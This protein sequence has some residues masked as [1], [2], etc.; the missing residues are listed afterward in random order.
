MT[1]LQAGPISAQLIGP[2]LRHIRLGDVEL[3]REIAVAVRD[4]EWGTIAPQLSNLDVRAGADGFAVAFDARHRQGELDFSW[5]GVISGD[6]Q[7][8]SFA[9]VGQAEADFA[10]RRIGICVLHPIRSCCGR[11]LH[12]RGPEGGHIQRMPTA[13]APQDEIDGS[14]PPLFPAFESLSLSLADDLELRFDFAGDLFEMEDQRNWTDASFKSYSRW[15]PSAPDPAGASSG[16]RFSQA[17]TVSWEGPIGAPALARDVVELTIGEPL[18]RRTPRLGVGRPPHAP[19]LQPAAAAVLASAGLDHLRI[20]VRLATDDV[21]AQIADGGDDARALG[22]DLELAVHLGADGRDD[23][24]LSSVARALGGVP[25][26]R[27]L[28]FVDG[29]DA[30]PPAA[31]AR[32]RAALAITAPNVAVGGGSDLNF[33]ELN[34]VRPDPRAFEVFSFPLTPTVHADD[35]AAIVS[36]LEAHRAV[37]ATIALF[38]GGRPAAI[39]PITLRPRSGAADQ[40]P[41]QRQATLFAAAWT[42][43]AVKSLGEAGA[44]SLTWF[45][46]AGPRGLMASNDQAT[47]HPAL[48]S[49]WDVADV[50]GAELLGAWSAEP[51]A[52]QALVMRRGPLTRIL[53]INLRSQSTTVEL[54]PV[55]GHARVRTLDESSLA[56]AMED[57]HRFHAAGDAIEID[58][59]LRLSLGAY[60]VARIDL[61]CASD[62]RK[63]SDE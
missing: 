47:A 54:V 11:M 21:A 26:A 39:S 6:A 22:A 45:E 14:N 59:R 5:H 3:V 55:R 35:D 18:G 28:V 41:D 34:R 40:A 24:A 30:T 43:A 51:A 57:P 16:A 63:D 50:A 46:T 2:A 13:V 60:A 8:L 19:P 38:D 37:I 23:D 58:G 62:T 42:A 20:D 44:N 61:D 7:Q 17:V 15:P 29:H 33:A 31:V 53:A 36:T 25:L 48:H 4:V 32:V 10:Y 27:V 9:M 1:I 56:A 12:A 49:L 52:A